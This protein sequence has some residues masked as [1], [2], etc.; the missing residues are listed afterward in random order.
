[1]YKLVIT[2]KER[3]LSHNTSK[4]VTFKNDPESNCRLS[5]DHKTSNN[6]T[7]GRLSLGH[8]LVPHFACPSVRSLP[9]GSPRPRNKDRLLQPPGCPRARPAQA[10]TPTHTDSSCGR[11]LRERAL[12]AP[13]LP[14]LPCAALRQR[15]HNCCQ[16][17][18]DFRRQKMNSDPRYQP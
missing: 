9:R 7:Q 18:K 10:H 6:N 11:G 1:M 3:C 16:T 8:V 17:T 5:S 13:H 14:G 4:A 12:L 2:D 15:S